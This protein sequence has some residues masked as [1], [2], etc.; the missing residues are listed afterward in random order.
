MP[1]Y[2]QQTVTK[3]GSQNIVGGT[4]KSVHFPAIS[5]AADTWDAFQDDSGVDIQIPTGKT[6]YLG[7][8]D[9]RS[10]VAASGN[11]DI[12]Y[13]DDATGTNYKVLIPKN[14]CVTTNNVFE[15]HLNL[16]LQIPSGKYLLI[17]N[18]YTSLTVVT[19]IGWLIEK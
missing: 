14:V 19:L 17:H 7:Y 16:H 5:I 15:E 8:L 9:I 18:D 10:T 13:A 11:T 2:K 6:G 12:G 1:N 3:T 4:A